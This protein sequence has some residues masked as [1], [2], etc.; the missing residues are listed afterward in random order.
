MRRIGTLRWLESWIHR[1]ITVAI[2][3]VISAGSTGCTD[4]MY[5]LPP[6]PT[7]T[8]FVLTELPEGA[9]ELTFETLDKDYSGALLSIR[10]PALVVVANE[11]ENQIWDDFFYPDALERLHERPQ[12]VDYTSYFV[13]ATFRGYA[14]CGGPRIEI[15]QIIR[16]DDVVQIY[17]YLPDYPR[18]LACPPEASSAYHLVKVRKEGE[19]DSEFTLVLYDN[20]R[21]VA[22][23][24]HFIP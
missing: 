8:P 3:L 18:D 10:H 12:D 4:L 20:D 22:E 5:Y 21:P 16:Q 19:W 17:A 2:L 14:G 9:I 7:K 23:T 11:A 13:L 15:K 1:C 6:P 24:K